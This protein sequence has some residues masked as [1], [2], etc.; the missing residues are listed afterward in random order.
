[1]CCV[2]IIDSQN[3]DGD[4]GSVEVSGDGVATTDGVTTSCGVSNGGGVTIRVGEMVLVWK[5]GIH[6]KMGASWDGPFQVEKKISPVTYKIQVPGKPSQSKVLHSNLLKKWSTTSSRVHRIAIIHEE[7]G[8]EELPSG[9]KL[10]RENI[11]PSKDQQAALD[12]VLDS[13]SDVI[14][15]E[16]GRTDKVKL[17]INTGTNE[18]VRSQFLLGGMMRSRCRLIVY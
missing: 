6:S 2:Q 11:V 5:P 1:M 14:S 17:S 13:F 7:E 4:V 16:P 3:S 15:P 12:L 9:L 8:E 10:D 18:P